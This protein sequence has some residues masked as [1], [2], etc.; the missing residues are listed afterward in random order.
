MAEEQVEKVVIVVTD[1]GP[2]EFVR[3]V[4]NGVESGLGG[5]THGLSESVGKSVETK[6]RA[7]VDKL[8]GLANKF[9]NKTRDDLV[10]PVLNGMV[11]VAERPVRKY[12]S[13]LETAR[14]SEINMGKQKTDVEARLE[15]E[16]EE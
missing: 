5:F 1:K 9:W 8:G 14:E 11:W 4:L 15:R 3:T 2:V 16:Y 13:E 10:V 7:V 12:E 6:T